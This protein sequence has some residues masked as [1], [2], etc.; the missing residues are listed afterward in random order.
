[1]KLANI[2]KI[3]EVAE[4]VC[5]IQ[6]VCVQQLHQAHCLSDSCASELELSI[7]TH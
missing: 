2:K 7:F 1:M 3:N 6:C 5:A 4:T